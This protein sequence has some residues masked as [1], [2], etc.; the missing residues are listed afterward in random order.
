[1]MQL[2]SISIKEATKLAACA[3]LLRA[4]LIIMPFIAN[5]W[6]S[7]LYPFIETFIWIVISVFFFTLHKNMK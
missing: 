3:S 4:F 2:T 6:F 7:N 5:G 1:M